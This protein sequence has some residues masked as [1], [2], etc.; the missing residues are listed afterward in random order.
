MEG[1][2]PTIK[3]ESPPIRLDSH[4]KNYMIEQTKHGECFPQQDMQIVTESFNDDF[5][6]Y[7][8]AQNNQQTNFDKMQLVKRQKYS[9]EQCKQQNIMSSQ[10]TFS[11]PQIDRIACA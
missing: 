10:S 3:T 9:E 5:C 6:C 2:W 8:N 1:Y 11:C 4:G 7:I